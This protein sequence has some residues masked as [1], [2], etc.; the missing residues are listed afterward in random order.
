MISELGKTF[1]L[2]TICWLLSMVSAHAQRTLTGQVT[3]REDHEPLARIVVALRNK[4]TTS[5]VRYTTTNGDGRFSITIKE[6]DYEACRLHITSM[7]YKTLTIDLSPDMPRVL[8]LELEPSVTKLREVTV[9]AQK[10]NQKGDTLVYNVASYTDDRDKSIGDVLQ[11]M[12]GIEVQSGGEIA[13]NGLPINKFY[14][15]GKDLL[16]GKYGVATGGISPD[17]VGSVEIIEKHQPIRVLQGVSPTE[18]AAINL[19]LKQKSKAKWI[20]NLLAGG[21]WSAQPDGGLWMGEAFAMMMKSQYQ[22][23]TLFKT[24]NTGKNLQG[25]VEDYLSDGTNLGSYISVSGLT[26]PHL[27]SNRTLLRR[28]HVFSTNNLWAVSN[29]WDLKAQLDYLNERDRGQSSSL[30]TYYLS[31][32]DRIIAEDQESKEHS[33]RLSASVTLEGNKE[34]FYLK[35]VLRAKMEWDDVDLST[36][37]SIDNQQDARLPRRRV[38]NNLELIKR[39]GHHIVTFKSDNQ[40]HYLPQRLGVVRDEGSLRQTTHEQMFYSEEQA[41]YGFNIHGLTLSLDGGVRLRLRSLD[42]ELT[43]VPDSLGLTEQ[44]WNT[45]YVQLFVTPK[46]EYNLGSLRFTLSSPLKYFHYTF[47]DQMSNHNRWLANPSLSINWDVNVYISLGLTGTLNPGELSYRSLYD[48]LILT[49][50]RTLRTGMDRF[51]TS[52]SRSLSFNLRFKHPQSGLFGTLNVRR[53]WTDQDY[54]T[55]QEFVDDYRIYSYRDA[56]SKRDSWTLTGRL[57]GNIDFLR[58]TFALSGNYV[59]NNRVMYSEGSLTNYTSDTYLFGGRIN[60]RIANFLSWQYK[61]DFQQ[62]YLNILG[63]LH[64]RLDKWEHSLM[65]TALLGSRWNLQLVGEYYRNEVSEG[66]YK[67]MVVADG[68]LFYRPSSSIELAA[69]VTNLLNKQTYSYTSHS[70]LS[71]STYTRLIRGREFLFTIYIKR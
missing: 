32:G 6:E 2:L 62:S 29:G 24:N 54:T 9:K 55:A 42:T 34:T 18:Q 44:D 11:K 64:Q 4:A 8:D 26:T 49:N 31:S 37:G 28:S 22:N 58:G 33:H 10:I 60:G 66:S 20:V 41:S 36:V 23:I 40:W 67:D 53:T 13:Y 48:G 7:G 56:N 39:W 63:S 65:L 25:E 16:G 5:V 47:S 69:T 1:C 19:R 14:I 50:Y 45:N 38:T 21:G 70:A 51:Y 71:S 35:N 59:R 43:G 15:E 17:D 27:K 52:D 12:P 30:V 3:D 46:L 68:K 61:L 57:S